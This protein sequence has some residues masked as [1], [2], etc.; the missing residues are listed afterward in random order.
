MSK[1]GCPIGLTGRRNQAKQK[2]EYDEKIH[3]LYG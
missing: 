2:G 3:G 1:A